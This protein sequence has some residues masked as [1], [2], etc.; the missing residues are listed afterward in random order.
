M[1]FTSFLGELLKK[2]FRFVP[3]KSDARRSARE[4]V[5]LDNCRQSVRYAVEQAG[6]RRVHSHFPAWRT[7][8]RL[9][10][11]PALR[12]FKLFPVFQ[13]LCRGAGLYVPKDVWVSANHFCVDVLDHFADIE[14]SRLPGQFR[15]K[16]NLHE[17]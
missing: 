4:L 13:Y 3:I 6:C 14:P 2:A 10:C 1:E 9:P 12:G 16:N 5:R 15:M 11:C 8:R 7:P 17:K